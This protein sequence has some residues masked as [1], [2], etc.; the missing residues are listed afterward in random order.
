MN[1]DTC[2]WDPPRGWSG[3][4][5]QNP[6]RRPW[7]WPSGASELADDPAPLDDL[8]APYDASAVL[9]GCSSA[10]EIAGTRVADAGLSVAVARFDTTRLEL[11]TDRIHD[12]GE[13][14]CVGRRLAEQLE[15]LGPRVSCVRSSCSPTVSWS[16]AERW[17]PA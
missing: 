6:G 7:C 15:A 16:T 11:V 14:Y 13:S 2:T 9:V 12:G 1:L 8:F 5:C 4:N 17:W 3:A 10:G